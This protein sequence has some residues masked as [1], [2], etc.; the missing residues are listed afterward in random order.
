[1][2]AARRRSTNANNCPLCNNSSLIEGLQVDQTFQNL[3]PVGAQPVPG[4]DDDAARPATNL[5]VLSSSLVDLKIEDLEESTILLARMCLLDCLGSA[6]AGSR[7]SSRAQSLA[8]TGFTLGGGTA[9]VW[10]SDNS[11]SLLGAGF[12]N[13]IASSIHDIDDGHRAALGHPGAAVVPAVLAVAQQVNASLGSVL[14][15]IACGYEAGVRIASSRNRQLA[16]GVGTGRWSAVA[17]AAGAAKLLGFS[18]GEMMA[19]I[20][21]AE[22]LAPNLDTA[23]V[24]GF[25]GGEVKEGIPW[26]VMTGLS[27]VYQAKEGMSGYMGALNNPSVYHDDAP[28]Y[29]RRITKP[30][31]LTTY[32]KRYACC[33][34][35]H[36]AIDA[37]L[38][39]RDRGISP[40]A[41]EKVRVRT[42][43]RASS[44]SNLADPPDVIA[45]Q[46]SVPFTIAAALSEGPRPLAPMD[47]LLISRSDLVKLAS[48]VEIIVVDEFEKMFPAKVPA[49]VEVITP[50]DV[51][52]STV[53]IPKGEATNPMSLDEII[54]KA[55][56]LLHLAVP[57]EVA[58][59]ICRLVVSAPI[60]STEAIPELMR[61]LTCH[62]PAGLAVV[63]GDA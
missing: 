59:E 54:A 26:S 16:P 63:R 46:F 40:A 58:D 55:R 33:R 5:A 45:A 51:F 23:D 39:I 12:L 61:L 24:E 52:T 21:I 48:K 4:S 49:Q 34:W 8:W 9:P 3:A 25:V 7:H 56:D 42:F 62:R 19:A 44:L 53:L 43:A 15:G 32:F 13:S 36:S 27:A 28:G 1:M 60:D 31:L 50:D 2:T 17:A 6:A 11:S 14:L 37:A 30:L 10:F 35:I 38:E 47:P 18:T 20:S 57:P 29:P 41:I 22:P